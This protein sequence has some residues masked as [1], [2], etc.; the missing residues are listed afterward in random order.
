MSRN[1]HQQQLVR[2]AIAGVLALLTAIVSFGLSSRFADGAHGWTRTVEN[3]HIVY[4]PKDREY[5]VVSS[6]GRNDLIYIRSCVVHLN[7][8]FTT[9]VDYRL[10]PPVYRRTALISFSDMRWGRSD[11]SFTPD[12]E[13]VQ[14]QVATIESMALDLAG[15]ES[16]KSIDSVTK[17]I[18]F[19]GP[20]YVHAIDLPFRLCHIVAILSAACF[21]FCSTKCV[22][23]GRRFLRHR[24][25]LCAFCG[26][27]RPREKPPCELCSECGI[28]QSD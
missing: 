14:A 9:W 15:T 17:E 8:S 16:V 7:Q 19:T 20:A 6:R 25:G 12:E 27:P 4:S 13:Q 28:P 18:V 5:S 22:R 3:F 10:F 23:H 1:R 24:R 2:W 11:P 21:G 26:Y